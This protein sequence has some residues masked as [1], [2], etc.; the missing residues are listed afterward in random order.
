MTSLGV[1]FPARAAPERLSAFAGRAEALGYD[2]LWVVEDCF[3]SGGLAL[4]STALAA[5]SRLRVG[6]GLLP[7]AVRNPAIVAMELATL[8]RLYPSRLTAAFGHGVESWMEQIGARPPKRLA[9]LGEVTDAVRSLL[10]GETVNA[11]GSHVRLAGVTLENP[12]A[13]PPAILIGTT[14]PKGIALAGRKADG[15]LVPEGC[16]PTFIAHAR[17]VAEAAVRAQGSSPRIVAYAWLRIEEDERARAVLRDAVGG[18]IASGLYP[19]P[20]RAAGVDGPLGPGP[21]PR[22]LADELAVAGSAADC[23]DA[24][25]RFAKAGA[26]SLVLVA[27][28]PDFE[29]QYE[30]FA[31]EVLPMV[32]TTD[33]P[34][35]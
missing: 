19:D 27:V 18:W 7:A 2:E 1:V 29:D 8:A 16:G 20:M 30:R 35:P 3:L 28:G 32:K 31:R 13:S 15:L 9:A 11:T 21:I 12:P 24:A 14:G 33:P 17:G 4:A 23:S 6:V 34:A 25:V 10:A 26:D 22:A 5:S